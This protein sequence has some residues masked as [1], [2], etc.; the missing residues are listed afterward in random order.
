MPW[1]KNSSKVF[2]WL[3][4]A[5]EK[6]NY[7]FDLVSF[8]SLLGFLHLLSSV[9]QYHYISN[10]TNLLRFT[11]N[12]L[13]DIAGWNLFFFFWPFCLVPNYKILQQTWLQK[14]LTPKYINNVCQIAYLLPH[15]ITKLNEVIFFHVFRF[16]ISYFCL[17]N[18]DEAGSKWRLRH[19]PY[20]SDIPPPVWE[21]HQTQIQLV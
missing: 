3:W 13:W 9:L 1:P 17:K 7:T 16:A 12:P 11:Q 18:E 2:S 4:T 5:G 10:L 20:S 14:S 6:K 19:L 8:S 15:D 21:K